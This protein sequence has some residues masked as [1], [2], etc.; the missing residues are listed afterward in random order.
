MSHEERV[1]SRSPE[2]S[3]QETQL[4]EPPQIDLLGI[5]N[6]M[7]VTVYESGCERP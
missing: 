5:D 6:S 4:S 1:R 2:L 7:Q 3:L